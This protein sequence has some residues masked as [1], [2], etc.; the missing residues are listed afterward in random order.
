MFFNLAQVLVLGWGLAVSMAA[1]RG[2]L[3]GWLYCLQDEPAPV[4]LLARGGE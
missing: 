2:H 1:G 4:K 3:L